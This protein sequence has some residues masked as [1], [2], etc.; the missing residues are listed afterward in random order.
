[1]KKNLEG[2]FCKH[3]WEF[4]EIQSGYQCFCCCPSWLPTPIGNFRNTSKIMNTPQLKK[5][6]ESILD[7]SFKYCDHGLCP[8][9]Q[10][11]TLPNKEDVDLDYYTVEFDKLPCFI[12][13]CYDKTCNLACPSCRNGLILDNDGAIFESNFQ[14]QQNILKFI[15]DHYSDDIE[16]ILNITG[17]GDPFA[18]RLYRELIWSFDGKKYPNVKF[19][20]QTN[21]LMLTQHYWDK[22]ENIA[23]NI[24]G[25]VISLD[26][27]TAETYKVTRGGDWGLLMENLL[28]L[29]DK[30]MIEQG[31]YFVRLDMVVS[32]DSYKD[33]PHFIELG[34]RFGFK[35]YLSKVNDWGH[36]PPGEFDR[37]CV[38]NKK[39]PEYENFI[40]IVNREYPV[41]GIDWG[42][43]SEFKND[44]GDV[45]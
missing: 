34:K 27:G 32:T 23:D 15:Q 8:H 44:K 11:G 17:S 20:F 43:L 22:M 1:M 13:F 31:R 28:L 5:I 35:M 42:N 39:H 41:E 14:K 45:K 29:R 9:I 21:G 16:V 19:Q 36:F 6:R 12:N 30:Q 10:N 26:A 25:F 4:L 3:P 24:N 33:I 2:K 18:S 7:G 37:L 40:K 38:W